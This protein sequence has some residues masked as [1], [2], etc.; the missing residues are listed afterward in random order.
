VSEP[1]VRQLRLVVTVDDYDA[2]LDWLHTPSRIFFVEVVETRGFL[3]DAFAE[4]GKETSTL[5]MEIR[6]IKNAIPRIH[7]GPRS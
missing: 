5:Y 6:S 7:P 4:R 2:A 3:F 1:T